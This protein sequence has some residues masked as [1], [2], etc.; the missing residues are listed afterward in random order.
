MYTLIARSIHSI[1]FKLAARSHRTS[2]LHTPCARQSSVMLHARTV[3]VSCRV[4]ETLPFAR[5]LR[6]IGPHEASKRTVGDRAL[7]RGQVSREVMR[8]NYLRMHEKC[9]CEC[10]VVC[11]CGH[12]SAL[13]DLCL[14]LPSSHKILCDHCVS[15]SRK[16]SLRMR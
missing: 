12:A 8:E 7:N 13:F 4:V 1:R 9:K 15:V 14:C 11:S 16:R 10:I 3:A 2:S 5:L 6:I